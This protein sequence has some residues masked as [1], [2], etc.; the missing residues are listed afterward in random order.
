MSK[1]IQNIKA[2]LKVEWI[3]A[4]E[5]NESVAEVGTQSTG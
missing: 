1:S 2:P 5:K 4:K 3:G